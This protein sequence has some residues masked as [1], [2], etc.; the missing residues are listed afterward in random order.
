MSIIVVT[1]GIFDFLFVREA[2]FQFQH[3]TYGYLS[4]Q[5]LVI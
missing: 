3:S 2:L 4:A 1:K 5:G